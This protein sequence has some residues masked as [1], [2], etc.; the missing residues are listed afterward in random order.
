MRDAGRMEELEDEGS[1]MKEELEDEGC[2]WTHAGLCTL[3][4]LTC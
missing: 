3:T 4:V 1:R 2:C